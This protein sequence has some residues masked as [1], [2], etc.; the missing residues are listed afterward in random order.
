MASLSEIGRALNIHKSVVSRMAKRGMPL[1]S[2]DAAQDW[3]RLN[4][5]PR[6]VKKPTVVDSPMSPKKEA[7]AKLPPPV[8]PE[9]QPAV[10]PPEPTPKPDPVAEAKE[11]D[12]RDS[13][14]MARLA[15]KV[16][17]NRFSQ[18]QKSAS[19]TQ[20]EF[21]K[22]NQA[23]ISARANRMKAEQD[24]RDWRR[25]EGITMFLSEAQEICARPHQS[26][27]HMLA[28]MPKQLAPRLAGQPIKEIEHTLA[29]WCDDVLEVIR[30]GI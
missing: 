23:Y 14:K 22:I 1:H 25:Q 29:Q 28:S 17:W 26:V 13:V 11:S 19:T 16:A 6:A 9:L 5:P 30:Q 21:R 7:P 15:E 27:A 20:E 10:Q 4:A 24:F 8:E 2:I 18:A 12:P 3:R